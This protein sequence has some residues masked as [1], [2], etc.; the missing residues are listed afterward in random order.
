[1]TEPSPP[2]DPT[3]SAALAFRAVADAYARARPGYPDEVVPWMCGEQPARV[4]ELGAGTGRLTA[5]LA[6][7]AHQV[8]ATDPLPE[9]LAHL[10][11]ALPEIPAAQAVAERI[12]LPDHSVDVVVSAQAYHWFDPDKALPEIARVLRPGGAVALVWNERDERI[13]WVRRLGAALPGPEQNSD[14]T[15]DLIGSGLFGYVERATFRLWQRLDRDRLHD[16]VRSRSHVAVLDEARR[17]E[18]LEQVDALYDE[19]GRGADGM[20]LPYL[21][22][23]FK[24]VVRHR[25]DEDGPKG[26]RRGGV[27]GSPTDP[28]TDDG[29][30]SLL[31]D[32]S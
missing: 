15:H 28:P 32:F 25:P 8:L 5:A 17:A 9:M 19:Y 18:V 24:A 7:H 23:C 2:S 6:A 26:P 29:T 11:R 12:P 21:T 3:A 30:G 1:M 10:R 22:R 4:L 16:L 14:P 20:L 13:P 31:I 27:D